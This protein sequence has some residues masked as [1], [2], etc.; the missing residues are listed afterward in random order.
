MGPIVLLARPSVRIVTLP[1]PPPQASAGDF[2]LR[3]IA[4]GRVAPGAE[5]RSGGAEMRS[6][7]AEIV[8]YAPHE[9]R[10]GGAEMRSGGAEIVQYAPHEQL[11]QACSVVRVRGL[12]G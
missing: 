8:Q 9:M 1:T 12:G 7:G 10:S 5:M 4:E 3:C 2:C 6:G 11:W